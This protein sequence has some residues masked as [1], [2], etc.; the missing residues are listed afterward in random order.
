MKNI[1]M[2]YEYC[3][4]IILIYWIIIKPISWIINKLRERE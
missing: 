2:L 4:I 3:I 1:K